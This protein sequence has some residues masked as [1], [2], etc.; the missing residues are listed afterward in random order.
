MVCLIVDIINDTT[1]EETG[2]PYPVGI[3]ANSFWVRVGLCV[4][5]PLL[6]P[7]GILSDVSLYRSYKSVIV[8][9]FGLLL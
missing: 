6:I 9:K 5:P 4:H 8:S 7:A 3:S 1:M 2:Y